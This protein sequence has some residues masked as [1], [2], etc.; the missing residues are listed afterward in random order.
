MKA[1]AKARQR[2]NLS[3]FDPIFGSRSGFTRQNQEI[4]AIVHKKAWH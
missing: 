1:L 3:L 2:A 4:V